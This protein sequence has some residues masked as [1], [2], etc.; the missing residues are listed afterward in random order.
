MIQSAF[1]NLFSVAILS[2]LKSANWQMVL[3]YYAFYLY[4]VRKALL[5]LCEDAL[6]PV[7][8]SVPSHFLNHIVTTSQHRALTFAP[9][10]K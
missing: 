10:N 1:A 7:A 8:Q 6:P 2:T 4:Y 9:V 3:Q 5:K